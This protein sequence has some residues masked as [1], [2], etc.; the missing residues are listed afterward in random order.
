MKE[1]VKITYNWFFSPET[2]EQYQTITLREWKE[3]TGR[4]IKI[5]AHY[6]QGEGDKFYATVFYDSGREFVI[7][8]PNTIHTAVNTTK[9]P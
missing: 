9:Q 2:G 5:E 3:A 8:N 6:P 1:I 4:V 7:F